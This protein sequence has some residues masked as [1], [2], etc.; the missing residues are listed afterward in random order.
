VVVLI[1]TFPAVL[2]T[3]ILLRELLLE[4]WAN[5]RILLELSE[6]DAQT[7][8]IATHY[9]LLRCDLAV[10]TLYARCRG[11]IENYSFDE[12]LS[13][14]NKNEQ[15]WNCVLFCLEK[16]ADC[17]SLPA[18]IANCTYA[19]R[20]FGNIDTIQANPSDVLKKNVTKEE[21]SVLRLNWPQWRSQN[22]TF[23]IVHL[24]PAV[25]DRKQHHAKKER[26]SD[27]RLWQVAKEFCEKKGM[28]F[29]PG[30]CSVVVRYGKRWGGFYRDNVCIDSFCIDK[31]EASQPDATKNF[32]GSWNAGKKIGPAQSVYGVLPWTEISYNDAMEACAKAGKRLPTLAQW[33]TAFS[34]WDGALWP[35]GE[36][37]RDNNCY[38]DM[39][40]GINPTGGCCECVKFGDACFEVC[41]MVGNVSEWIE[42]YWC[43]HCFNDEQVLVAGGAAHISHTCVNSQI[44]DPHNPECW[45]FS[46]YSQRR[47]GLHHHD[48][49]T[50]FHDDG[51][52]CVMDIPSGY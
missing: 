9:P 2:A 40:S 26:Q 45:V 6:I 22:P 24:N 29:I 41:D 14:C 48:R 5:S 50:G 42:G 46:S 10:Y 35:W 52:R 28:T 19:A 7:Q 47:S 36:Q 20:H 3:T 38:V 12:S 15:P 21:W 44:L 43:E 18:C 49:M 27:T 23:K 30:G 17:Q 31:Y 32:R 16:G 25:I 13:K 33:Q 51:F 8:K 37:W 1:I 11:K 39:A 34:G 4:H